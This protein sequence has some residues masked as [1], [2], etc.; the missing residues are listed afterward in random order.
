[1]EQTAERPKKR[2]AF[3]WSGT[4]V[5]CVLQV[6]WCVEQTKQGSQAIGNII[7]KC[8]SSRHLGW[9]VCWTRAQT[10]QHL[11]VLSSVQRCHNATVSPH[12]EK[13]YCQSLIFYDWV[14]AG[15]VGCAREVLAPCCCAASSFFSTPNLLAVRM[16]A[17]NFECEWDNGRLLCAVLP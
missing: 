1:M 2:R 10:A 6:Y 7:W 17:H 5:T 3:T 4:T 9:Q 13:N 15:D 12:N 8:L 14:S 11:V 16:P